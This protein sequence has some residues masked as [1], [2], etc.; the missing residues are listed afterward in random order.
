MKRLLIV[1]PVVLAVLAGPTGCAA[2]GR[3]PSPPTMAGATTATMPA[4]L[5][6]TGPAGGALLSVVRQEGTTTI[7]SRVGGTKVVIT[8]SGTRYTRRGR[9]LAVTRISTGGVRLKNAK[10]RTLWR[11][12]IS[13][14]RVQV[15]RG[16][17]TPRYA[18][19]REGDDRI[20]VLRGATVAG[21]VHATEEGARLVDARGAVLGTSSSRP[22]N[23]MAVLLCAE[24]PPDLRVILSA[25]LLPRL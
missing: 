15:L 2:G 21:D 1:S 18:F 24:V 16:E 14:G 9:L 3:T 6:V 11:V 12:W 25:A 4:F 22:A 7:T 13:R 19:R 17:R 5:R 8:G 20:R 10:G 23:D